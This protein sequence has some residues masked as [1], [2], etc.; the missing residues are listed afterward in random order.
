M[1]RCF[2]LTTVQGVTY[3][4]S[5]ELRDLP[6]SRLRAGLQL[7]ERHIVGADVFDSAEPHA[8]IELN[9]FRELDT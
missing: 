6:P 7:L 1:R 2:S 4:A 3:I 8:G 5:P 9:V